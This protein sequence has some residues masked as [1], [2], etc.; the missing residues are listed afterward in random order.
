MGSAGA[1]SSP[2]TCTTSPVITLSDATTGQ[3][4]CDATLVAVP[5]TDAGGEA[6]PFVA[7]H[8]AAGCAYYGNLANDGPYTLS[9]S[10]PGYH[11]FTVSIRGIPGPCNAPPTAGIVHISIHAG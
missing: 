1:C 7:G 5:G 3:P 4:V 2:G 6:A 8:S 10:A 9:G 11:S